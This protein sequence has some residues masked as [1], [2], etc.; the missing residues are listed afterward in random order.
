M[1]GA[2][3]IDN[4]LMVLAPDGTR[5]AYSVTGRGPALVLT[6]GLTT[7]SFFW[8]YLQPHWR[9]THTVVTWDLP[10]HGRSGPAQSDVS[11]SITGLPPL[12]AHVM[13]AAGVQS[14]VQIGWSVGCQIVLELYRQ[15]PARCTALCCLF[16]PAEHALRNTALPVPGAWIHA[17]LNH[18][19][20]VASAA[21]VQLLAQAV[22]LP[23]G[24]ALARALGLVGATDP[25]VRQLL[26]DL[27]RLHS[28]TGQRM[29]LAAEAH[30]A[31]DVLA[32]LQVPLLILAGERDQF[33]P[34]ARVGARMHSAAPHSELVLVQGATHTALLDHADEIG[35][36]VD[37]F[38]AR[39]GLTA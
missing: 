22:A 27:G 29:A 10:G 12:L 35:D 3:M 16:G 2:R 39:H 6:N 37:S 31:F 23:G 20:G 19:G 8:K 11:A 9:D 17:L 21:L 7:S 14:A 32:T 4:D 25:D 24:P 18:Q 5:I 38:L 13:D 36:A 33:A 28:S 30:S 26:S 34:P 15:L 1:L